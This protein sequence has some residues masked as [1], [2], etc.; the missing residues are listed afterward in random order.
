MKAFEDLIRVNRHFA[1]N[2]S[3]EGLSSIPQENV[4]IITCMDCRI[5]TASALGLTPG[6]GHVLRN[7]GG[8]VTDDVIRSLI[9]SIY[10]L[11]V[12]QVAVIHHTR[13]GAADASS[14]DLIALIR[15]ATG[16]SPQDIDFGL[17]DREPDALID[18]VNQLRQSHVLPHGTH[19]AGFIYDVDTGLLE[20]IAAAEVGG[21][22]VRTQSS[23]V[24]SR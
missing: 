5:D 16:N 23:G 14:A 1:E 19:L 22:E 18:D 9:A 8:R 10:T 13:C 21:S 3:L 6:K 2:F 20:P 15:E 11:D 24:R 4:A 12:T 7:A 17:I